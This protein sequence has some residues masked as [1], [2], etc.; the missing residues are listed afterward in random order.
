MLRSGRDQVGETEAGDGTGQLV[1]PRLGQGPVEVPI[2]GLQQALAL[3]LGFELVADV[4]EGGRG[5][6]LGDLVHG[7][8]DGVRLLVCDELFESEELRINWG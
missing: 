1:L 6:Q 7:L 4:A 5:G 3:E 8:E 2:Q